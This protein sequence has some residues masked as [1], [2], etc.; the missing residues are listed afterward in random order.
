MSE[1]RLFLGIDFGTSNSSI[2]S[3]YHDPR[4]G[5][6][7]II[8][9]K[10]V[11]VAVEPEGITRSG[12]MPTI[13]AA[14]A[15][16][17]RSKQQAILGW[18]FSRHFWHPWPRRKK[19]FFLRR[20]VDYFESVKSDLGSFRVYPRAFAPEYNT[21][22]KVAEAIIRHLLREAAQKLSRSDIEKSHAIVTVPASLGAEARKQTREAAAR[23]GLRAD[24]I[25]LIDEP[26]AA[27]LHLL[28]DTRVASVLDPKEPKNLLV[29]DYGGGTLDLCLVR[30]SFD[31]SARSGLMAENLAISQYRRNGGNDIDRAVMAQV[32]WP[33]IEEELGVPRCD[34]PID[35]RQRIED[36]FTSTVSR[37]LKEDMCHKI[38][39]E[40]D[41]GATWASLRN[42]TLKSTGGLDSDFDDGELLKPVRARFA[43]T[44]DQFSAV[45]G[46]YLTIPSGDPSTWGAE[47]THS[48][49]LPIW[50]TI[51]KAG[52][53]SDQVD[54]LIL[55][56][57][58]CRN[59]YVRSLLRDA[60]A[61]EES[62]FSKMQV[63]E[64]PDL[65]TSVA[66]GA[67][68]ACYWRHARGEEIIAPIIAEELGVLTL[69]EKPVA[70]VEAGAR[71]PFPSESAVQLS[72]PFYVP[73]AGQRRLLVPFY[74]GSGH[75]LR[76]SGT[77]PVDLPETCRR[78]DEVR[79][80]FKV[81]RNKDV[82][83]WYSVGGGDYRKADP[84]NDPWTTK[85]LTPAG[86]KLASHRRQMRDALMR[87]VPLPREMETAEAWLVFLSGDVDEAELLMLDHIA[88]HVF[89]ADAANTLALIYGA[90]GDRDTE[91]FFAEQAA[92]LAPDNPIIIGNY[93]YTLANAGRTQEAI[94][95]L[96][97]AVAIDPKLVYVYERLGD[98]CREAGD[99]DGA[100]REYRQA[101][102]Y[103]EM[104]TSERPESAW[105]W[106]ISASLYQKAGDYDRAND[107]KNRSA[108]ADLDEFYG[109][110]HRT[111]IAGPDSGF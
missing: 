81:D 44:S 1:S 17:N 55:H 24:R 33:Q 68:L 72:G 35:L 20:G 83:W 52:L 36:T 93:G 26:I 86:R 71:L 100:Q 102:R 4:H 46:P 15:G 37:R 88:A 73:H 9:V 18:E 13:V 80:K 96:R 64:T 107:A 58:S 49:L 95:H 89:G 76:L 54:A 62:L 42:H 32:I 6:S 16:P 69:H 77:V 109:G 74:T 85:A 7:R 12:R 84:L 23:A 45:M 43:M 59:P 51:A 78:G 34:L 21:P 19:R 103:A 61:A 67:A 65:D 111:R 56:G 31:P 70:L 108:N 39:K 11:Q 97:R 2:A 53:R 22:E 48:L 91:L 27:L 3:V 40:L 25:E 90:K 110:D 82:Q 94:A 47:H 8:D 87:G 30:A 105:A 14:K 41:D 10:A 63:I 79:I 57:G 99:E 28:N 29:F 101:I 38:A 98:I 104:S 92:T 75:M 60:L 5:D 50:E 66:C 106:R